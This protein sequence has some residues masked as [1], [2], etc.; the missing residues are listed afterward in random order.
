M[1]M[2]S[3]SVVQNMKLQPI[4][5]VT[6]MKRLTSHYFSVSDNV[7]KFTD[8]AKF[9]SDPI[10]GATPGDAWRHIWVL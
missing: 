7:V 6:I 10:S 9:G 3:A 8:P 5:K 1:L 2:A 4:A